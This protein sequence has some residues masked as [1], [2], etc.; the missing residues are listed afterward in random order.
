M[1]QVVPY[2]KKYYHYSTQKTSD[3][4]RKAVVFANEHP[5]TTAIATATAVGIVGYVAAP[6]ML[7]YGLVKLGFTTGGV[8]KASLAAL[9]Q[10]KFY[11]GFTCGVFSLMQS[12][13]ATG[14]L[15]GKIS[16]GVGS[17]LFYRQMTIEKKEPVWHDV[18][19]EFK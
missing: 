17:A 18:P 13:G 9:I 5:K 4:A 15:G 8:A 12:W 11:G 19:I 1:E 14:L 7:S 10:S 16:A 2:T 3:F 6:C